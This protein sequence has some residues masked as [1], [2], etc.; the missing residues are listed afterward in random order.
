MKAVI[1][2]GGRGTRIAEESQVR[3][4]PMVK[5]GDQPI[6]WHIMKLYAA[7]GVDDFIVCLGYLGYVIK[8][9]FANYRLHSSTMVEFDFRTGEISYGAGGA[10]P[11]RVTLVETGLATQ[12]GGRLRRVQHL[13]EGEDCF[14]M[15]YGD[16]LADVDIS[17][18][19][20]HH[21][22]AGRLATVT[23]VAPPGRFGVVHT[24]GSRVTAF[25]EKPDADGTLINGGF[26]VLSPRALDLIEADHSVWEHEPLRRLA[27]SDQL[28][29][30]H[31]TGF[32]QPMDTLRERDLLQALW[33]SGAPPWRL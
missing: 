1:L 20:A 18:V 22:R 27:A 11:W 16:G 30:Y 28:S 7:H 14:C 2:A 10:E 8:E 12:T 15:T 29:A 5:I 4:K 6:L 31:H 25:S 9:Y 33:D 19:I 24:S 32:W 3:P 23:T 21:R 17:A 13:L 26:F